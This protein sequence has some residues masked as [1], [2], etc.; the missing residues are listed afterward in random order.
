MP[1]LYF[2]PYDSCRM[3]FL[4]VLGFRKLVPLLVGLLLLILC[5]NEWGFVY[6]LRMLMLCPAINNVLF[7]WGYE[8]HF[9]ACAATEGF[10]PAELVVSTD[11]R[12]DVLFV[13]YASF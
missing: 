12:G 8:G 6:G 11:G 7:L 9:F 4:V 10:C 1:F 13:D 5:Y 2:Q 3:L